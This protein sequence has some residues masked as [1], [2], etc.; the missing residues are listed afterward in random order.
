MCALCAV[1]L[2]HDCTL[3]TSL[4]HPAS[5][6]RLPD[7]F[8]VA[9]SVGLQAAYE[10]PKEITH[11]GKRVCTAG[12]FKK[13]A[14]ENRKVELYDAMGADLLRALSKKGLEEQIKERLHKELA[15]GFELVKY[16]RK[17]EERERQEAEKLENRRQEE[18]VAMEAARQRNLRDEQDWDAF[19]AGKLEQHEDKELKLEVRTA[20]QSG[21]P[22]VNHV[23]RTGKRN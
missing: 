23:I 12:K 5:T 17:K 13:R 3:S 1:L 6:I 15:R 7:A 16:Q 9:W 20:L 2:R 10:T 11:C 22:R 14:E 8:L 21:P 18:L 4:S 19:V